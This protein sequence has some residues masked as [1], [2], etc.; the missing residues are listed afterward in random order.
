VARLKIGLFKG[1]R[2][3]SAVHYSSPTLF[4]FSKT[5]TRFNR[6]TSHHSRSLAIQSLIF[7]GY[8]LPH[9]H[10]P[11]LFFD[12]F[13]RPHFSAPSN[14]KQKSSPW[15]PSNPAFSWDSLHSLSKLLP[16]LLPACL[17][18]SSTICQL[19]SID[20][21]CLLTLGLQYSEG[22]FRPWHGLWRQRF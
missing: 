21:Q 14:S 13:S 10:F 18:P 1:L 12:T 17:Q 11:V 3:F 16:P 4:I 22:P 8:A 20:L 9:I 2:F 6:T 7:S 15:L 19:C 5:P